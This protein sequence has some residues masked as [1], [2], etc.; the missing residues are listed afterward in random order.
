ML[1]P[2]AFE[3]DSS[4]EDI[5]LTNSKIL[6]V[7]FKFIETKGK[8]EHMERRS[9]NEQYVL[10]IFTKIHFSWERSK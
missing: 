3:M 5:R 9:I 4:R 6:E 8:E 1:Q 2:R 10:H 7:H